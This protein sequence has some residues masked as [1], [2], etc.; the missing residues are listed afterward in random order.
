M[1][2]L[3]HNERVRQTAV[4]NQPRLLQL[5]QQATHARLNR[6]QRLELRR[7]QRA[8]RQLQL[9]PQQAVQQRPSRFQRVSAQQ[10][11]QGRFASRF[12]ASHRSRAERRAAHWA[13]HTAWRHGR[14]ARYVPWFGPIYWPYVYD[15]V[16]YYT[17]WPDG[18]DPGY[19]A[20]AYDDFFDGIFFPDGAPY[21]DVAYLGPYAGPYA[22]TTT[23]TARSG[24]GTPGRLSQSTRQF[25]EE[26]AKGVA[27]WP[28]DRIEQAVQPTSEQKKLLEDLKTAATQAAAQLK[29]ACPNVVSLT[30][31]GR[32]QAMTMRLQATL[33]AV[34]VLRPAM[35]AFY[36]SLND[37]QK[38][39][40]NEIGPELARRQ[41]RTAGGEEQSAQAECGGAKAGLSG[42]AVEKIEDSVQPN[43][44]Q[45]AALDR[46]DKAMQTAVDTLGKACPTTIPSTPVGRLEVMQQRLE[47]MIEAANT[48]RPALED[49]YAS[50]NDEQKAKFNRLN[51]EA[52]QSGG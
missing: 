13:A 38:A 43:D 2:Q 32:L 25:C 51:R 37:E 1:L 10:T 31:S 3:R 52:T 36:G 14:R 41:Q 7:L 19:W 49:F 8:Q 47:A 30:P 26:Q 12:Y 4:K 21:V 42:L 50:L 33:D 40:F 22:R 20:Y 6:S 11:V 9:Q 28:F 27:A 46:L 23:G 16:F 15:D 5:Q 35:A 48:V 29:E 44:A 34:K 18:Y 45:S 24:G 39:R 17:F